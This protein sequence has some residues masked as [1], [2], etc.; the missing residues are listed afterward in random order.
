M[1]KILLLTLSIA[2]LAVVARAQKPPVAIPA[3][4]RGDVGL[5]PVTMPIPEY[6]A[7]TLGRGFNGAI[8]VAI[9]VDEN[10]NVI[11][12]KVDRGP[13][14]IC[15]STTD[16][17]VVAIRRAATEAA[18]KSKFA[19]PTL[20]G[21]LTRSEGWIL[22]DFESNHNETDLKVGG[23]LIF[24]RVVDGSSAAGKDKT[25]EKVP[26]DQLPDVIS[27]AVLNGT[28]MSLPKPPYPPAAR[29]VRASGAVS[30]Q[31]LI[32]EH[33]DIFSATSVSGHPLLRAASEIAA[34]GAKFSPTL[35]QGK[36]VKVSGIITYNFVP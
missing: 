18:L 12:A 13:G 3:I 16:P 34:C 14:P 17:D 29:A 10:G 22:Y 24:G 20:N 35:L 32:D 8:S 31:V 27:G 19:P 26:A 2:C 7:A 1:K 15:E 33:G 4:P 21:Q 9:K 36:P 23:G 28:A 6:P 30:V 25:S 5:D 11:T